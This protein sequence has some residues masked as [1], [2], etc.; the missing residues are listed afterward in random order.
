M[1]SSRLKLEPITLSRYLTHT[2]FYEKVESPHPKP[3]I[4]F[5]PDWAFEV[6]NEDDSEVACYGFLI[7]TNIRSAIIE[8][9]ATN[10]D[11]PETTQA[12]AIRMMVEE[13][14]NKARRLGCITVMGI[15]PESNFSVASM[16]KRMGAI[17]VGELRR[18]IVK[19][20]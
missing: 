9:L 8:G 7:L 4:D 13:L 10:P 1:A 20:L 18:L 14:E 12:R 2:H 16:Y 3:W 6:V 19:A 15:T 11:L 5:H 17:Q